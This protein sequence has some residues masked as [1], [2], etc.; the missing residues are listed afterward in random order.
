M[1][2]YHKYAK[3]LLEVGV[4]LKGGGKLFI[5]AEIIHRSFTN[6][7][8]EL[9]YQMGASQVYIE[10][11]DPIH[12]VTKVKNVREASL[13]ELP[14][15]KTDQAKILAE[16]GWTKISLIGSEYP[17][18]FSG[19]DQ[20][21]LSKVEAAGRKVFQVYSEACGRGDV[22]WCVAALPTKAWGAKVIGERDT[23]QEDLWKQMVQI[24]RLD[25]DDPVKFW[26][27]H[28]LKIKQRCEKLTNL[29]L[30]QLHFL[31]GGTDLKMNCIAKSKWVGGSIISSAGN[32]FVP[33]LPT[34]E[35][36]TTPDYRTAEGRAEIVRPVKVSGK[37]VE[38]AW[39]KF[40]KGEVVEYGADVNKEALDHF[41]TSCDRA[42]FL[43]EVAIVDNSSPVFQSGLV[44]DCILY[45]ENATS[46]IALGSSYPICIESGAA[47]TKDELL[48][49]GA[50][51]SGVHTDFMIGTEDM[52]ITGVN[53]QGSEI[54]LLEKGKC[55]I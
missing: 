19:L 3:L 12:F 1:D 26:K 35:C 43:G 42:K 22:S 30:T 16:E 34:E 10:L 8:A 54:V 48:A 14:R 33:N 44:F 24:L 31:G 2:T 49:R 50:N 9:A 46:H 5:S 11:E 38:G 21:R 29:Q 32:E 37:T 7:L 18:A 40:V 41:F 28:S 45:D 17:D 39:F 13:S 23:A 4:D 20:A 51:V 6:I 15:W 55:V 52:K 36:F 53:D 25:L 27:D 47:K